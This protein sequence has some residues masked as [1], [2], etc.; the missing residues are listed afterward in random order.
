MIG[1]NALT[2]QPLAGDAH[3]E[4]SVGD[5]LATPIGTRVGLRDYGS[6][7]F[8]LVDAPLNALTRLRVIAA[9]AGAI[10]R[11]EPRLKLTRVLV[12]AG[13]T[14]G[15]AGLQLIGVRTDQPGAGSLTIPVSLPA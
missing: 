6:D 15:Q 3:L 1:T 11:W 13:A 9:T 7:L 12:G 2:G 8:D 5:I 10:A 14:L 4:Q